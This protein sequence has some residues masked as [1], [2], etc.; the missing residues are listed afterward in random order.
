MQLITK[1]KSKSAGRRAPLSFTFLSTALAGALAL[2]ACGDGNNGGGGDGDGDGDAS[3]GR[4]QGTGGAGSGGQGTGATSSGGRT[5]SGGSDMGGMDAGGRSG[6]GGDGGAGPVSR[7][8]SDDGGIKLP[9]GF[10]AVLAAESLGHARHVTVTPSGDVFVAINPASDGSLAGNIVGLRD[11]DDDGKF[12]QKTTFNTVGGNGI[13]WRKGELFFAESD[14]IIKYALADGELEPSAQP[15]VVVS[16]LP[17]TGDH[18]SKTI[19]FADDETMYVNLG[20]AS[21]SCQEANRQ[22]ESPGNDPCLE[23]EERAGIWVF[24]PTILDQTAEDGER[25]VTG[26]R[27]VNALAVQP[28]TGDLWGAMNGRDQLYENW[29][30]FYEPE[31]DMRIPAERLLHLQEGDDYGWPYCYEDP[32]LGMVLA[33]EYGGDGEMVG[34]C[35]D[36]TE[37]A[38][39]FPGHW[40]PLGAVFYEGKQFPKHYRGGLFIAFHGSRFEPT[41]TGDLPGYQVAFLPVD[42]DEVG[43]NFE[44]FASG[45]AGPK[46]PL[47][48][49]AESRPVGVTVA[50]DGSLYITDDYGGKLWRVFYNGD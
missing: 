32:D 29:P 42:G 33:P 45:F 7:C 36:Y 48:E 41:A 6:Q 13:A 30:D 27:N 38:F 31:D 23:L 37:A 2:S 4:E 43:E 40:A 50:N 12:D 25:Y 34:D 22:L 24:D 35:L 9:D 20:S 1:Q 46:R 5:A 19:A 14:R 16:G 28:K 44:T 15:E 49:E 17:A 11:T 10:C 8:D 39:T 26:T 21:N 3:G 47:P 18:V